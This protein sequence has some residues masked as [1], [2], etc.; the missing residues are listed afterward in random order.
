MILNLVAKP[1]TG[2]QNLLIEEFPFLIGRDESPFLELR[3]GSSEKSISVSQISRRHAIIFHDQGK[4]MIRDLGSK[5]ATCLNGQKLGADPVEI[6]DGDVIQIARDFEYTVKIEREF[7]KHNE[8]PFS[9]M[10][11]PED[12]QS[13]LKPI[14]IDAF[15][16]YIGRKENSFR[17]YEDTLPDQL[18]SLSRK[19]AEIN[20]QDNRFLLRDLGSSNGTK[21]SG[22]ALGQTPKPFQNGD[23]VIFA[24]FFKYVVKIYSEDVLETVALESVAIEDSDRTVVDTSEKKPMPPMGAAITEEVSPAEE[25]PSPGLA[26][27]IAK[28][29]EA[30]A[31][32]TEKD[33]STRASDTSHSNL[34]KRDD[35]HASDDEESKQSGTVYM[36]SATQFLKILTSKEKK[37]S[38]EE[39]VKDR[40]ESDADKPAELGKRQNRIIGLIKEILHTLSPRPD[41]DKRRKWLLPGFAAIL[42][43]AGIGWFTYLHTNEQTLERLMAAGKYREYV[44]LANQVLAQKP[45][46]E[47]IRRSSTAA[48]MRALMPEFSESLKQGRIDS[49]KEIIRSYATYASNNRDAKK[50]LEFLTWMADLEL[51]FSQND[52]GRPINLFRDEAIIE[53]LVSRWETNEDDYRFIMDQMVEKSNVF[54]PIR[55]LIYHHLN[56]LELKTTYLD[57]AKKLIRTIREK[58]DSG[59]NAEILNAIAE[60]ERKYPKTEGLAELRREAANFKLLTQYIRARDVIQ[61][62]N[63]FKESQFLIPVFKQKVEYLKA[64]DLPGPEMGFKIQA[65][66]NAWK[67]GNAHQAFE[68]LKPL[69]HERWGDIAETRM[70]HY[71]Q[72]MDLLSAAKRS[73]GSQE[74]SNHMFELY[75]ILNP[76][77]DQFFYKQVE[78]HFAGLREQ[79]LQKSKRLLVHAERVWNNYLKSGRITGLL[80]LESSVS[81]K[82]K[83]RANDLKTC[84]EDS[85]SAVKTYSMLGLKL[86]EKWERMHTRIDEEVKSQRLRIEDLSA[87]LGPEVSTAKLALLPQP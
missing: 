24:E 64:N 4:M 17:I 55:G 22:Q 21:L 80:R 11:V 65:A 10:L 79:E 54:E 25:T 35:S 20:Y 51:F 38:T 30:P 8:L 6:N 18:K 39:G 66:G 27:Q 57:S 58:L 13:G 71:R 83:Q 48:L 86:P 29:Y 72:V 31:K 62:S 69:V 32:P 15:P 28:L 1:D 67:A 85:R 5:N 12:P 78:V 16:Y 33:I 50:V 74:Q 73:K 87:V 40:A 45:D 14:E 46:R 61:L 34:L 43:L 44:E 3:S 9:L 77:E 68:I 53:P 47:D 26:Q 70:N 52:P 63:F 19:H 76:R 75:S 84:F 81:Q 37:D 42:A 41:V 7:E 56:V 82:F 23:Q 36:S 60:Y 59:R 49:A 2:I